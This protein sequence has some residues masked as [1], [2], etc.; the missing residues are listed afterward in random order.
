MFLCNICVCVFIFVQLLIVGRTSH[1]PSNSDNKNV[2]L[3][4]VCRSQWSKLF[5]F[6]PTKRLTWTWVEVFGWSSITT[7]DDPSLMRWIIFCCEVLK[8]AGLI[9]VEETDVTLWPISRVFSSTC[10][11]ST[12]WQLCRVQLSY[13]LNKVK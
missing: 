2:L 7:A 1:H 13:Y 12:Q 10:F 3:S 11:L 8:T 6:R 9:L 4:A 5:I